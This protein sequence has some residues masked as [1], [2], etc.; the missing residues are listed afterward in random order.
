[1]GRKPAKSVQPAKDAQALSL[2]QAGANYDQIA[3]QMGYANKGGAYKAV[4]RALNAAIQERN[5]AAEDVLELELA[6]LD[7][8]Q[9]GLWSDA[10]K[11]RWLAVDRVLRIMERRAAYLGLDAPKRTEVSGPEG[12]PIEIE[13]RVVDED[14]DA[15]RIIDI[16]ERA[17]ARVSEA[18]EQPAPALGAATGTAGASLA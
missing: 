11:G 17:R 2:R 16:V 6:R 5:K 3:R 4:M 1:M 15:R 9:L 13:Q 8:M 7:T 18:V 10:S 14:D 12:G